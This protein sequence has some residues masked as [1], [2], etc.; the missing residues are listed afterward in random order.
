[1]SWHSYSGRRVDVSNLFCIRIQ[2]T[3]DAT[4]RLGSM[5]DAK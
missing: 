4:E 3:V 1:M 2:K 5:E